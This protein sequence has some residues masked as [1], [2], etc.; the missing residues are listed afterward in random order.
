[1]NEKNKKRKDIV[2]ID[3]A[4]NTE[5]IASYR[6]ELKYY[7]NQGTAFLLEQRLQATMDRDSFSDPEKGYWVRSLYFDDPFNRSVYDKINGVAERKKY[8]I[9]IY[10]ML[11]DNIRLE[12]KEK[13]GNFV[14][15]QS[16]AL[17]RSDCDAVLQ[18]NFDDLFSSLN[19]ALQAVF[20]AMETERYRPVVLVDYDRKAFIHPLEDVRIT[21]DKNLRAGLSC[22]DL[23]DANVPMVR[24]QQEFDCI[25]EIKF[26]DYLPAYF[27]DLLQIGS[28]QRSAISKYVLCRQFE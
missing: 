26:N 18:G 27:H 8:R 14:R 21:L 5:C 4:N 24:V 1:M 22:T 13:Q 20:F 16:T 12:C 2:S 7:I 10:N 3:S 17:T 9:R 15:K 28:I 11:D 6:H 25:L 23:F 19:T